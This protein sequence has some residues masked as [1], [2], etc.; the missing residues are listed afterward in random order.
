MQNSFRNKISRAL[1]ERD[2]KGDQI[3]DVKDQ[4]AFSKK[5]SEESKKAQVIMQKAAKISQ[6]HLAQHLSNIV[7]Q[8]IQVVIEKPYEFVCEFVERRGSTEADLYLTKSGE[9]YDIL[10]STGGGLGD[11]CSFAL[12]VAYLLLSNVDRVLIIDEICRHINSP[13]QREA[14]MK[15]VKGLSTEFDIQLIIN[16]AIPEVVDSAETLITVG[17]DSS[18]ISTVEVA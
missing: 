3:K 16:S 2:L 10:G 14:F 9:R 18:G 13:K 4:L 7:T 12:K 1:V 15:V 8:A 5:E 17:Q 11:V 6:D